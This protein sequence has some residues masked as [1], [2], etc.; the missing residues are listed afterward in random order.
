[1]ATNLAILLISAAV[2]WGGG[3]LP[4]LAVQ[5][6]IVMIA[7]SA[8]VW[9][10]YVQHQF[11]DTEWADDSEWAFPHAALRGSSY[12]DLPPV[13][14]WFSA[15]VGVHHVHHLASRIPHYRL[16]EV[17]RDYPEL[18]R[19]GRVTLLESLRAVKFV[20]WDE[21]RHKIVS[22]REARQGALGG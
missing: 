12:Y 7:G 1:M 14:N 10:F 9:L 22:F 16:P 20:L 3:L 21:R 19:I 17:L 2:I 11:E 4:F 18:R 8:G 15:N 13:L 5:F 6:L